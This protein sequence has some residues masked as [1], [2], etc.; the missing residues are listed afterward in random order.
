M[1]EMHTVG[2]P[3]NAGERTAFTALDH[4]LPDRYHVVTNVELSQGN[5]YYEYDAIVVGDNGIW[6]VEVKAWRGRIDGDAHEWIREDGETLPS[7][8][9]V[10]NQKAKVLKSLL[11]S[12]GFHPPFIKALVILVSGKLTAD[13]RVCAGEAVVTPDDLDVYF[14]LD[15]PCLDPQVVRQMADW[16]ARS[17]RS[18]R[19]ERVLKHYRLLRQINVTDLYAEYEAEHLHIP[20]RR[21]R[22]KSY[23]IQAWLPTAM[24]EQQ[25]NRIQR[26]ILVISQLGD[27]PNIVQVYDAFPDPDDASVLHT[28]QE[29]VRGVRLAEL[30]RQGPG[31][32]AP[33]QIVNLMRQACRA[34]AYTHR[35][36]VLHRNLSPRCLIVREDGLLK[37]R[38]FDYARAEGQATVFQGQPLGDPRYVAPEQWQ[39]PRDTDYRSDLFSL[40]VIF[41]ELLSGQ[42][43]YGDISQLLQTKTVSIQES[44]GDSELARGLWRLLSRMVK[45]SPEE[46]P[47]SADEVLRLLRDLLSL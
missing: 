47:E 24:L 44:T 4:S 46:R 30:I 27:H 32:V 11:K 19:A 35:R 26:D 6:V 21:A 23:Y 10:T 28:F 41:Y 36:G 1:A 18:P 8:V 17:G 3:V 38:D 37:L 39:F 22:L 14:L 2:Q 42:H 7:P 40:G 33:R 34:L 25:I 45:Y 13:L 5:R 31:A 29:W 15:R 20:G 9:G 16:L 12:A 43:P